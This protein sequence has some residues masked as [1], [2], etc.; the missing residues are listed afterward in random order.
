MDKEVRNKKIDALYHKVGLMNNLS[1]TEV[2]EIVESVYEMAAKRINELELKEIDTEEEF[3]KTKTN[4]IF[5]YL[6]KLHTNFKTIKGR[7]KQS[8]TFKQINKEKWQK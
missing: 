1:K 6:G 2:K 4:F 5:K 7:K 8:D 3:D